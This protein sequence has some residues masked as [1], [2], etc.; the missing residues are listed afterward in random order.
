[1]CSVVQQ[2]P[3]VQVLFST[4]FPGS[5]IPNWFKHSRKGHTIHLKASP[6]WYSSNFLGFAVSAVIKIGDGSPTYCNLDSHDRDSEPVSSRICSFTDDHTRE[7]EGTRDD[8]LWLAY[9]PS[10]FGFNC[11]KW[12]RIKF[13][14]HTDT[15]N[16]NNVKFCGICPVYIKSSSDEVCSSSSDRSYSS[17]DDKYDSDGN[18]SSSDYQYESDEGNPGGSVIDDLHEYNTIIRSHACGKEMLQMRQD[19]RML[20]YENGFFLT[21]SRTRDQERLQRNRFRWMFSWVLMIA[22]SG[23]SFLVYIF[24]RALC[25]ILPLVV[26][27]LGISRLLAAL[28]PS[29]FA[30]STLLGF[31]IL[32]FILSRR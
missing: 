19:P 32:L 26:A 6:N 20:L 11:E 13:T 21:H 1:M 7:L 27:H 22:I 15:W 14:F 23:F 10:V 9:I 4:V 29:P 8:H 2:Y 24:L 30:I 12:S 3:N 17:S 5:R 18:Y 31:V 28:L 16:C 25:W